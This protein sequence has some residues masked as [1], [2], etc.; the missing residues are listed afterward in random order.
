[1][2]V[3]KIE[4]NFILMNIYLFVF[5][6]IFCSLISECTRQAKEKEIEMTNWL[7]WLDRKRQSI[8][9]RCVC[10]CVFSFISNQVAIST[11][12]ILLLLFMKYTAQFLS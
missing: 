1:M 10:L 3:F 6:A 7:A 4:M 12:R 8:A 11:N 2:T 9:S 5:V